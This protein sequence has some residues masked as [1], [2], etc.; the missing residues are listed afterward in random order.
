MNSAKPESQPQSHV[1]R[2]A[3]LGRW[4]AARRALQLIG[5]PVILTLLVGLLAIPLWRDLE[6][7]SEDG[8]VPVDG[9]TAAADNDGHL[10]V[11]VKNINPNNGIATLD[12]TYVTENLNSEKIDLW[13]ISGSVAMKHGKPAYE[14]D[15]KLHRLPIVMEAPSVFVLGDTRRATYKHQSAEIKID[16]RTA[17]YFCPFDR[18]VVEFSF[19]LTDQ[20]QQTLRPKLWCELEDPHFINAAPTPVLSRSHPHIPIPTSFTVVLDRPMYSKIFLALSVLMGLGC[21]LWTLYKVA[22]LPITAMES[23][24]LLAF[25][26]TVLIAVPALRGVFVPSNLQFAPLFDV[27]VILIWMAGL[28][29]L[30]VNIFRHDFMIHTRERTTADSQG[31]PLQFP[32]DRRDPANRHQSVMSRRAG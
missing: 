18:Y 26:F 11:N 22:Y 21:V 31:Q 13:I 14:H 17:G 7:L 8:V 6:L 29:T 16:Q 12:V 30:I 2:R 25:D 3:W 28:L 1:S 5:L 23:F 10:I 15:T 24:S 27:F 9:P 32:G 4:L 20:A 19:I